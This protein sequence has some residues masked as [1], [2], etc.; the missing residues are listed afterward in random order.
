MQIKNRIYIFGGAIITLTLLTFNVIAQS[1]S[2]IEDHFK[3]LNRHDIKA[4]VEGYTADAQVFS[5]N[6]E[7]AKAGPDSLRETYGRYFKSTPNLT[8]TITNT[9]NAGDKMIVEYT[10]A[11][12]LSNPEGGEPEYMKGKKYLLKACAIFELRGDKIA[13]ETVYFDQVAFLKQVGF[14]DQH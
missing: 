11:G 14:F 8:Y 5:P 9:I 13:K 7:G 10:W 3:A 6:W 12:A 2:V 1:Q 4:I